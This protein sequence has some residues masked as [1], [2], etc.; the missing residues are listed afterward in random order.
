MRRCGRPTG[1]PRPRTPTST[2]P[3]TGRSP[4]LPTLWRDEPLHKPAGA[5]L[6]TALDGIIDQM[7]TIQYPEHPEVRLRR[8]RGQD[9]R[10]PGHVGGHRQGRGVPGG[11]VGPRR[12]EPPRGR[13]P[14]W[15]APL[16]LG[17]VGDTHFVFDQANFAWLNRFLQAA[18]AR[19]A[20][21]CDPGGLDPRVAGPVRA[22]PRHG[23]PGHRV[24]RAAAGQAV[25]AARG[26][27]AGARLH[28]DPATTWSSSTR[29]CPPRRSGSWPSERAADAVRDHRR[30]AADGGERG[31]A[32][33]RAGRGRH[34]SVAGRAG[35]S[36]RCWRP[37]P[38]RWGWLRT[39]RGWRQPAWAC[40]SSRDSSRPV[41]TSRGWQGWRPCEVPAEPQALA[42][43][44]SSAGDL[45]TA[46]R[47]HDWTTLDAVA[48]A[49]GRPGTSPRRR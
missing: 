4:Q 15:R 47:R 17:F 35:T 41:T 31:G 30:A 16:G 22:D 43:S 25:P 10:P 9:R 13:A 38:R 21:R 24:V 36:S 28:R 44:M 11:P 5:T 2:A 8:R 27:R 6:S 40:R 33:P 48:R 20:D 42:Q 39:R 19:G 14:A 12:A 34:A 45:V 23:Q 3:G 29:S 46:L 26:A 1:S 32:G 37:T 7:L 18:A 49:G